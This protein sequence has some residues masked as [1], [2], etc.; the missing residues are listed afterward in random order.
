MDV[1]CARLGLTG[2]Q[3]KILA[4][5][6]MTVDHIGAYLLPQCGILRIVGRL[7]MPVFA[8]MIAEGCRYT[9]NRVRYL[10]TI[11][12]FAAVCQAVYLVFQ[13]SLFQCIL[14][15]FSLSIVL[16][17]AVD[18]AFR[19]KSGLSLFLLC[20]AFF[21]VCFICLF[22]PGELSGT[23][24]R[25]DYGLFGVL[26]P[27]FIYI[28]RNKAEKL[29]MAAVGLSALALA[30]YRYQWYALLSLPLLALYNG[31]RGKRKLKYLFYVYYPLHLAVIYGIG[32][33]LQ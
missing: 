26:L 22:L 18:Y 3:L 25:V 20:A 19:K 13:N 17:Y 9:K 7:A 24:F 14:V 31:Q 33:L 2:N 28:G 8:F 27:V 29:F 16:I 32:L 1:K 15:T 4:M 23:D 11:A 21:A 30:G 5:L 10:L 6:F 12:G